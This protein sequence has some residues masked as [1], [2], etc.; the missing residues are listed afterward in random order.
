LEGLE[1][2]LGFRETGSQTQYKAH[3]ARQQEKA[4][5]STRSIPPEASSDFQEASLE[6]IDAYNS[7]LLWIQV[8]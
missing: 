7:I 6:S 4:Y 1:Q 8:L 2:S 5:N 3:Q